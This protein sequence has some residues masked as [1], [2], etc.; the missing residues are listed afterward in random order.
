MTHPPMIATGV[1]EHAK[2]ELS[3]LQYHVVHPP[4]RRTRLSQPA[5]VLILVKGGRHGDDRSRDRA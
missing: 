4:P 1:L 3:K 5:A 2:A